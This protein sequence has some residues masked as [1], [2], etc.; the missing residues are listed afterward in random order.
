MTLKTW[1]NH[2]Q[3]LLII[4]PQCFFQCCQKRPGL[5][6]QLK[7]LTSFSMFPILCSEFKT[8]KGVSLSIYSSNSH[9]RSI[10]QVHLETVP[11]KVAELQVGK[12]N[13]CTLWFILQ[14]EICYKD[15]QC[16]F[17]Y[18]MHND[19]LNITWPFWTAKTKNKTRKN[20]YVHIK[21]K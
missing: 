15:F 5:P 6:R 1:K 9:G 21:C 8:S 16:Y 12:N 10:S 20:I 7:T 2:P 14:P 19:I 11:S 17:I 13:Q 18:W 3:K 4:S